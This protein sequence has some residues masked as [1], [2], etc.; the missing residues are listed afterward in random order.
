M[1]PTNAH[2]N[3]KCTRMCFRKSKVTPAEYKKKWCEQASHSLLLFYPI[4]LGL[5]LTIGYV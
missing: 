4:T 1:M 2:K 3:K 5:C